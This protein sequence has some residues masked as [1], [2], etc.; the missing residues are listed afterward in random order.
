MEIIGKIVLYS[1]EYPLFAKTVITAGLCRV[2][3]PIPENYPETPLTDALRRKENG[4]LLRCALHSQ[5]FWI[6]ALSDF[7][8][9]SK[10]YTL[11]HV[12]LK[13]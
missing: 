1:D 6:N 3:I 5:P 9:L 4:E 2:S 13:L 8:N 7:D 12:K 11:S 10:F